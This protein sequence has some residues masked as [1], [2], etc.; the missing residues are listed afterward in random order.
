MK[1]RQVHL[2]WSIVATRL[3]PLVLISQFLGFSSG[4]GPF[5]QRIPRL[6][7]AHCLDCILSLIYVEVGS[8]FK[9]KFFLNDQVVEWVRK[10]DKGRGL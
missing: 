2:S 10:S 8:N 7:F 9:P 1:M 3:L 5:C 6:V 4:S